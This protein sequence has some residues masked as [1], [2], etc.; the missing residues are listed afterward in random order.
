MTPA[1]QRA[2][3]LRFGQTGQALTRVQREI[4]HRQLP[5]RVRIGM[6][7]RQMLASSRR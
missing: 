6:A 4:I 1:D 7:V 5:A 2:M 3:L